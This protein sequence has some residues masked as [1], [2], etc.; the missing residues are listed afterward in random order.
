MSIDVTAPNDG[1]ALSLQELELYHAIMDYRES[2]GLSAIRLSR[3]LTTTANRHVLDTRENV[4]AARLEL[5]DGANLHSWSDAPYYA[6]G[7]DPS[8][9]WDAPRR[10]G[11]SY[12]SPG[13][14]ISAAG[15]ADVDAALDG[16]R[17]SAAHD[18]VLTNTGAWRDVEFLAMGIGV[19]T[20]PG[21]G[22]FA[23]RIFHVWFGEA[24][25]AGAPD[26]VGTDGDDDFTVT[27]FDD[28]V[29]GGA[30]DDVIR[31][32][33]GDDDLRGEDGADSLFG[34]SG[35]DVLRGADGADR[36][37]AGVHDDRLFGGDGADALFGGT[38]DD[39]LSGGRSADVL[40]GGGGQDTLIGG[41]GADVF[42]LVAISHSD[43]DHPDLV[44]DFRQDV[45]VIDLGDIDAR[46]DTG[47]DDAF[48]FSA[49]GRFTGREGQIRVRG[50]NVVEGDLDGD[51]AADFRIHVRL[52]WDDDTDDDG[53]GGGAD[54]APPEL[55]ADDFLL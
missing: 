8:V 29:F 21:E 24:A 47:E 41:G 3:A 49:S 18:A 9:M 45:D 12:D 40:T 1:D 54:P 14:E 46:P 43:L 55:R 10:V 36:L 48:V 52:D 37:S 20:S 11:T 31:G 34:G 50:E 30:G 51:R 53:G 26:I 7:R 23:G 4:W 19:D 33:R 6:D 42:R 15:F 38:G 32:D 28:R 22:I 35:E 27:R 16:W 25:D 44:L 17:G 2:Q 5:P 13:Y 39:R